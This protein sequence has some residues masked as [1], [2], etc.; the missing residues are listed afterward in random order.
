MKLN[1]SYGQILSISL[2]IML[3]SAVQNVIA[4]SD[5]VFL[6][7]LSE[8]DFAAIGFVSVFYLIIAAIGF[9]FSKGGQILIARRMGAGQ[10]R[11]VGRTFYAMLYFEFALAVV[12]FLFMYYGSVYFFAAFVNSQVIYEKSL[13]YIHYRSFGVFFSY[14]GVAIVALYTGIARTTFIVINTLVLAVVNIFLNYALIFGHFGLPA[15]GI[16]GAAVASSFAEGIA[17]FLFIGY[18]LY[19]KEIRKYHIFEFPKI[20]IPLIK[21]QL[22]IASPIVAQ[23]VVGLGS[24]F[25]FFGI[26]ENLGERQL[27]ITNLVRMVYLFLSIPCWGFASGINTLVSNFIGARKRMAV[28]PIIWKTAKLCW[29]ITMF[30]AL[31]IAI[32]P[33]HILYPLLGGADMSLI[34]ESRPTLW[35]L[36]GIL[37]LFS[38]GGVYFNGLAGTGATYFGLKVQSVCAVIYIVAIYAIVEYTNGGL[39]WAWATEIFYWLVMLGFTVWYLRSKKWHDLK[40]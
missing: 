17:F 10:D 38:I 18:V 30:M 39:E 25:V 2:P 5:S 24:W 16:G 37:F 26:V 34:T 4:L 21:K 27:A 1:T 33:E 12:M 3:G 11:E 19:D 6:Y 13:E 15:M 8:V 20:D 28:L 29:L 22:K 9:G 36:V 31:P 23:A 7:H 32:W 35:V 40:M 14:M